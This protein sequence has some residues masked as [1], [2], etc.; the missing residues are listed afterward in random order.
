MRIV[1]HNRP[2]SRGPWLVGAISFQAA[3]LFAILT[4][5]PL[6]GW[7]GLLL[8][9]GLLYYALRPAT[10]PAERIVIEDAG[11]SDRA[12]GLGPIPWNEIIRAELKPLSRF[13][14]ISLEVTDPERWVKQLTV[15]QLQLSTMARELGISPVMLAAS[16]LDRSPDE[17]VRLINDRA[18]GGPR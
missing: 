4:H 14:V 10:A 8:G 5:A 16:G 17:L 7:P 18:T 3:G 1:A 15:R 2:G 11:V 6:I 12:F 9:G 13:H